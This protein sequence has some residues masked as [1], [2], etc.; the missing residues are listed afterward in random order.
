MIP[1]KTRLTVIS[2]V[3]AAAFAW[4][5]FAT[6]RVEAAGDSILDKQE[7]LDRQTWWDNKDWDWYK[8]NIR[9][10]WTAY[11]SPSVSDWV[12]NDFGVKKTVR[13]VDIHLWGDRGGVRAPK[14]YGIQYWDGQQWTEAPNQKRSPAAPT[15]MAV[16]TAKVDPITTDKIRVVFQHDLPG[17]SGVT[18]W[19]IWEE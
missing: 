4:S 11:Q 10:R 6:A 17:F 14:G 15:I 2:V 5:A 1:M 9:N 19:M 18:E 13:T 8:D 3:L 7:M 12:E 16:N